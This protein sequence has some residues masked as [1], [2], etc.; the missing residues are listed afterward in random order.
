[1]FSRVLAGALIVGVFAAM[2]AVSAGQ[3]VVTQAALQA[4]GT[5]SADSPAAIRAK[6]AALEAQLD[7]QL[8][9]IDDL[10]SR[11]HTN[12]R[13]Q[14]A[15]A[16]SGGSGNKQQ[17]KLAQQ[18]LRA[19][20]DE[21]DA[22]KAALKDARE[23]ARRLRHEIDDAEKALRIALRRPSVAAPNQ[24]V[25]TGAMFGQHANHNPAGPGSFLNV[26]WQN[27]EAGQLS[28]GNLTLEDISTY[29]WTIDHT[30]PRGGSLSHAKK[31]FIDNR[32]GELNLT[33]SNTT[34]TWFASFWFRTQSL[35]RQQSG[36]FFRIWGDNANVYL[37]TGAGD[38]EIRGFSEC[39]SCS[40]APFTVYT[41]P[42][43]FADGGWHRVD[44]QITEAPDRVAVSLDGKLQWQRSST[45]AG[46]ELEQ[47]IPSSLGADGHTIGIGGMLDG[48]DL[49][50]PANGS[51]EFDDVFVD[52]TVARVE[53]GNASTWDASTVREI[54]VAQQ[55]SDGQIVARLNRGAFAPGQTVY[56]YVVDANGAVNPLG[57]P[58]TMP[59]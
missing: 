23:D 38:L 25:L 58:V 36:K 14:E 3:P 52:Y 16:H 41:S 9:L 5:P 4:D 10:Q 55:W 43:T 53:L 37:S 24:L 59:R 51:Y 20:C 13:S 8:V 12:E 40:P 35:A 44:V 48:P 28:G 11:L 30:R 57:L 46:A 32:L 47:W 54:Q 42:D 31:V 27:F 21:E 34:G 15:V 39:E 19:L 2:P 17:A 18:K 29:Q 33:Q 49:G 50:F 26:A 56:A 7:A 22:L 45:L 6:I 1:M